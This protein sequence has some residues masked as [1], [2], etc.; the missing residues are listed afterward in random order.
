MC[1]FTGLLELQAIQYFCTNL[2]T[3]V[4]KIFSGADYDSSK[5]SLRFKRC[6]A[7]FRKLITGKFIFLAIMNN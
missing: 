5:R 6:Q 3:Y 4:N 2:D 7:F 1:S